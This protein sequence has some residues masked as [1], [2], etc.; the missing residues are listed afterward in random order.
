MLTVEHHSRPSTPDLK[1]IPRIKSILLEKELEEKV[2]AIDKKMA[3]LALREKK[4]AAREA[5]LVKREQEL[6]KKVLKDV[7]C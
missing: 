2:A 7:N 6:E 1:K 4:L 3:E 5:S